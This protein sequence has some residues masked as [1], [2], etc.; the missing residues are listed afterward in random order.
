MV[1]NDMINE[2]SKQRLQ[3]TESNE[4]R[5]LW[6]LRAIN[7]LEEYLYTQEQLQMKAFQDNQNEYE[8]IN[9]LIDK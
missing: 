6:Y 5:D 9:Y 1:I 4:Q 8:N 3:Y 7:D 2:L